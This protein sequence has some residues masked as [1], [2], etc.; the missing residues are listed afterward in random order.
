MVTKPF[1]ILVAGFLLANSAF[2]QEQKLTAGQITEVLTGNTAV[3]VIGGKPYRQFFDADGRTWYVPDG[4][5]ADLGKWRSD[6]A[7]N[8]YC[9]WWERGGWSCYDVFGEGNAIAWVTPDGKTR[10][11]AKVLSGRQ[12]T[13]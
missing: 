6:P 13:W 9:S 2:A 5:P 1:M 7:S 12:V 10:Y 3:G 4:E 8:Q 11:D